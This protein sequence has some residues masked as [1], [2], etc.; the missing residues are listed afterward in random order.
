M[1]FIDLI[2]KFFAKTRHARSTIANGFYLFVQTWYLYIQTSM[3]HNGIKKLSE[4]AFIS[5]V[6]VLTPVRRLA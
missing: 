5:V 6:Y 3:I 2:K 1:I 4:W